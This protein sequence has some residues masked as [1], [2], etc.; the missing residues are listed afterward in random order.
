MLASCG[1]H[2]GT[3]VD[4]LLDAM[5]L[6]ELVLMLSGEDNMSLPAISRLNI[7][8]L[9][10]TDGP[11]GAR[12][13][14]GL[15]GGV[16]AAAF[17]VGISLGASWNVDMA[18]EIGV[19]LADE[20]KQKGAHVLLG[21]TINMQRVVTNGRNFECIS[22]E[23]LIVADIC[24]SY[25][26][27]L[28]SGNVSSAAKHFL[29]NESEIDRMTNSSEI[30]ERTMRE[31][32]LLPFEKAV[33]V[34]GVWTIMTAY[35]EVNGIFT[36][37]DERLMKSILREEWGYDGATI[38]NWFGHGSTA[39]TLNAG[40][41][42]E[43]P[44]PTR[45]RGDAVI[46][47]I[48]A[49]EVSLE[50]VRDRVRNVLR[51]LQRTGA[52]NTSEP[53]EEKA[54]DRP[55]TRELIR[56][57]GA[58][59]TVLL[60]NDG[61]LP[62]RRDAGETF[63]VIGPNSKLA[64]IMGG[65]SAQFDAH[66]AISPFEGLCSAL[67]GEDRLAYSAGCTNHRY[68]PTLKGEFQVD[69]YNS[70]DFSGDIA[71]TET[72]DG[73]EIFWFMPNANGKTEVENFS[74][75]LTGQFT[76]EES[77]LHRVGVYAAGYA[78]VYVDGTLIA[79]AHTNWAQGVTYFLEGCDEMIGTVELTAGKTYE[80]TIE[81]VQKPPVGFSFSAAHI[82]I[83]RPLGTADI[84]AAAEVASKADVAFLFIGRT[85][86]W[87]CGGW[88]LEDIALP[89]RQNE[90]VAAVAAANPRTVVVLQTGG[91]V[92]MPWVND[93]S[94]IVE[95]WY[96]GQ[97]AGNAI[98]DVLFG[99]AEPSGRLPQSFPVQLGDVPTHTG[100]PLVYPGADGDVKYE[101]GVFLGYRHFEKNGIKPL[102]P[103]GFGLG[104]SNFE[105]S[106]FRVD[107]SELASDDV[108]RVSLSVRNTSERDGKAVIQIYVRDSKASVPRPD[109]ELKAFSK[110]DIAAGEE[111][112]VTISL[113]ARALAYYDVD[114]RAWRAEAGHFEILGALSSTD[115]VAS[116]EL[117]LK[118][119]MLSANGWL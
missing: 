1:Y 94:A 113:S 60:K 49:N 99:D 54:I 37:E 84:E 72:W 20:V 91:P 115:V 101:E 71:C 73:G 24:A 13:S 58:E 63:A 109:K 68:E 57:A 3:M 81:F 25:I 31:V 78:K 117:N 28:Q 35:N 98:A 10:F 39:P 43:M 27:G 107:A 7:G 111:S 103:F 8:K 46:K 48:E 12:G 92:E 102:F 90:L 53:H 87:D 97:E 69:Y 82:G 89:G 67:G 16:K 5:T 105:F 51:L 19:A 116:A 75:R 61:L 77:G 85:S 55:E 18:R 93:V 30:D 114:A 36:V 64:Q 34:A 17:P 110:I 66:Y 32:Y 108:I 119:D 56:R 45:D 104:Y 38:S 86:Q 59:G 70:P 118:E 42:L 74:A 9:R 11:N 41:D 65:G 26:S 23:P 29:G 14:G 83:G 4:E 52:L 62:L 100:D 15:V 112:A 96:P 80:V 44:G 33:K 76:P 2:P 95:A 6:S 79:D 21:P 88:D 106:N 50:T 47:A 22:E 40:L